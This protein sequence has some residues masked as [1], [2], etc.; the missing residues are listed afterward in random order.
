[1]KKITLA[2]SAA[3][4]M[5][6]A[7][8]C[9]SNKVD[10]TDSKAV[11]A[12][13]IAVAEEAVPMEKSQLFGELPSLSARQSA[14][15][16]SVSRF[17]TLAKDESP[18]KRDAA[19]DCWMESRKLVKNHYDSLIAVNCA[20]IKGREVPLEFDSA[21]F[22]EGKATIGDADGS[23]VDVNFDCVYSTSI[24]PFDDKG[25]EIMLLDADGNVLSTAKGDYKFFR[26]TYLPDG[27]T[28]AV[29]VVPGNRWKT[30][31]GISPRNNANL[32]KIRIVKR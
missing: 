3:T 27:L 2:V 19:A 1:M 13:S 29:N 4:L 18:E 21:L 20:D 31:F 12:A 7:V 26:M 28:S 24:S 23:S 25:A 30:T 32:A 15:V 17:T 5:L 16:D 9:G 10:P 11:V 6:A 22:S 14:A 8:S